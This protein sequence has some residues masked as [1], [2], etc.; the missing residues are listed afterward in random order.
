MSRAQSPRGAP[1]RD[2]DED[3]IEE[4]PDDLPGDV[5]SK[6]IITIKKTNNNRYYWQW[7]KVKKIKSKYRGPVDPDE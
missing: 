7:R 1:R 6:A 2:S 3:K 5:P 4:R